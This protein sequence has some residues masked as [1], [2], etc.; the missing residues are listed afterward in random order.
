LRYEYRKDV[1]S[2][3]RLGNLGIQGFRDLGIQE[4]RNSGIRDLI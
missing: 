1:V 2:D 4:F 3:V